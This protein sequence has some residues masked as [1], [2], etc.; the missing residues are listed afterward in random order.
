LIS[1]AKDIAPSKLQETFVAFANT[2]G[3]ELYIGIEDSK[4]SGDRLRGFG[5][6]EEA[7][8]I[9]EVL[10]EQTQPSVENI[11]VEFL[12]YK[13]V[14]ILHISIPKSPKVHFTTKNKCVV[15]LNAN[16]KEIKGERILALG[17]AKGT[18]HYEKQLVT[19]VDVQEIINSPY[20]AEYME[21]IQTKLSPFDFLKKQRLIEERD[22]VYYPN[23]CCILLFDE[24]PQATL[25]TR[26][27]IKLYRMYTSGDEYDRKYLSSM[28]KTIVGNLERMVIDTINSIDEML[29]D[30]LYRAN[31]D[32]RR[33]QY[34]TTAIK[35]IIVNAIIHRDYSLNDDIHIIIYDNPH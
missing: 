6:I 21:R 4:Y 33:Q 26:C 8:D 24:E 28:P 7:N 25:D 29:S 13:N 5:N 30:T 3:G 18:Y 34:P 17:Y 22:G 11:E 10:L 16:N 9:L 14:F 27:S 15:R 31:G 35:E 1:K 19:H 20:L 32:L 2:D 23:V 12:K